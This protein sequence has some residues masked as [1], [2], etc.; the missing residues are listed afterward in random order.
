M[1]VLQFAFDG[2]P[3]NPFL[4][5]RYVHNTVVYTGTHD[6]D[7]TRGW[8]AGLSAEQR[9]LMW[10]LLH[11]PA[12]QENDVP[13]EMI[14]LALESAAAL[15]VVPLQDL[16]GLTAGRMNLPGQA[17]GNWSWRFTPDM[18]VQAALRG[19][20]ELCDRSGRLRTE[21]TQLSRHRH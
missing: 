13:W 3:D 20:R 7:T 6:N 2:M 9:D 15:A 1:R 19:L 11:R 21:R 18:P 14:R 5:E 10:R 4:P 16:L 17:E 8:Y 12:C